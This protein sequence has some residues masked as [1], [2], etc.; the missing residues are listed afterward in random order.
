MRIVLTLCLLILF[1]PLYGQSNETTLENPT[2]VFKFGRKVDVA[3]N[4]SLLVVGNEH[5]ILTFSKLN[6]T[7]QLEGEEM[8]L[9]YF[10]FH[11]TDDG[12]TL[13]VFHQNIYGE[14]ALT[15]FVRRNRRW[16]E[17]GKPIIQSTKGEGHRLPMQFS[18]DGNTFIVSGKKVINWMPNSNPNIGMVSVYQW[19]GTGWQLKGMPLHGNQAGDNFGT[20]VAMSADESTIAV[21]A[22][23]FSRRAKSRGRV[24]VFEFL[25]GEWKSKG[26]PMTGLHEHEY[27]GTH[28][29]FGESG[30]HLSVLSL[31]R[32][33]RGPYRRLQLDYDSYSMNYE[34][35][36][37]NWLAKNKA[38]VISDEPVSRYHMLSDNTVLL[39]FETGCS[40][41]K[42]NGRK[43]YEKKK[44]TNV[45]ST[46]AM[47]DGAIFAGDASYHAG[48]G[49]VRIYPNSLSNR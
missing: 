32:V 30:R 46:S 22:V 49:I 20:S 7:W 28:V 27:F 29:S 13:A 8:T 17:K 18:A 42:F 38:A 36:N 12:K 14:Q 9:Q 35:Q 25:D 21:G 37:G 47:S 3:K 45:Y 15:V 5:A 4:E 48:F 16:L 11:L 19:S 24:E 6:D 44:L 40:L 39:Y 33:R 26:K 10:D 1:Q 2:T 34:F 23:Y 31:N 43:W 41:F